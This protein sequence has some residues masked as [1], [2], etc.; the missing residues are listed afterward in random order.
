VGK[1]CVDGTKCPC[2]P[3]PPLREGTACYHIDTRR[4]DKWERDHGGHALA[5]AGRI[6][7]GLRGLERPTHG[8]AKIEH[9]MLHGGP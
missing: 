1:I 7:G 8:V 2:P 4:R 5:M 6:R 9:D 3:K